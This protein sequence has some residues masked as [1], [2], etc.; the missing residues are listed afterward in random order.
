MII[1]LRNCLLG[2]ICFP[3]KLLSGSGGGVGV[4]YPFPKKELRAGVGVGVGSV[5]QRNFAVVVVGTSLGGC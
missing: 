5:F 4:G 2:K 3:K 1:F